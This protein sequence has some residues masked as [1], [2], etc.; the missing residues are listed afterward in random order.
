MKIRRGNVGAESN[1]TIAPS[2]INTAAAMTVPMAPRLLIHL[3][4][5]SPT[6]FNTTSSQ[7]QASDALS[8]K[9][10]LSANAWCPLPRA[11]TETPTK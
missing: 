3:P 10:L 9:Y 7:Q 4:T 6:T 11:N 8:A 5:P 1:Q 2:P